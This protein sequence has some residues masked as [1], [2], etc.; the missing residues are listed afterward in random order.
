[1]ILQR[2]DGTL[3]GVPEGATVRRVMVKHPMYGGFHG[4]DPREFEPDEDSNTAEELQAWRDACA[5]WNEGRQEEYER[6][7]C[8]VPTT[9]TYQAKGD[10]EAKPH[11]V[12][13]CRHGAF[14]L[15]TYE[16]EMEAIEV[17]YPDGRV[18]VF[19]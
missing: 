11:E 8:L 1:M 6:A 16:L 18:Q 19:S 14:G 12:L 7:R 5:A 9:V 2:D 13:V 10:D 3:E 17:T 15:G 4:G